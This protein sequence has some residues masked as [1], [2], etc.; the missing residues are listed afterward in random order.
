MKTIR[1][2]Y[3][4][5]AQQLCQFLLHSAELALTPYTLVGCDNEHRLGFV[6]IYA[7]ITQIAEC[8]QAVHIYRIPCSVEP[9][10]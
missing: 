6:A 10:T 1:K 8:S 2:S 5:S 4:L 7:E 3:K 9:H